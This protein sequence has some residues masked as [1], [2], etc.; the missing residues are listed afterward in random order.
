MAFSPFQVDLD[1]AQGR[2]PTE[3]APLGS[4]VLEL[5]HANLQSDYM[6]VG[7]YVEYSQAVAS[8]PTYIKRIRFQVRIQAPTE[9]P[10]SSVWVFT[11]SLNG[12]T[13]YERRIPAA[14]RKND[15]LVDGCLP[16][17][18]A[19]YTSDTITFRLELT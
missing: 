17:G 5:G 18:D 9:L 19:T 2:H 16:L 14:V 12:T 8:L 4:Y 10:G 3:D 15:L 7:D 11:A 1:G 13:L 6:E